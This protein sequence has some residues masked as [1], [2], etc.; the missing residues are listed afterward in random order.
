[1]SDNK[2]TVGREPLLVPI[3]PSRSWSS[4]RDIVRGVRTGAR[5][6]VAAIVARA[7]MQLVPDWRIP[8]GSVRA[9]AVAAVAP[10]LSGVV[11]GALVG[12]LWPWRRHPVTAIALGVA[13]GWIFAGGTA[14]GW[15]G[16]GGWTGYNSLIWLMFGGVFGLTLGALMYD[17]GQP[18]TPESA[19]VTYLQAQRQANS[20][21][22][23]TPWTNCPCC[24]YPTFEQND[25]PPHCMLCEWEEP[26]SGEEGEVTLDQSRA[27]F[28]KFGTIYDPHQLPG[29]MPKPPSAAV[30][31]AREQMRAALDPMALERRPDNLAAL[32]R[33]FY[34]AWGTLR[35]AEARDV[36]AMAARPR[37]RPPDGDS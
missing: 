36:A 4:M 3:T 20:L 7:A 26:A 23:P 19:R 22:K 35:A 5:F 14:A 37:R 25:P 33:S 6:G 21:W 1:M 10:L 18:T 17:L 31:A 27:N 8:F 12:A 24:G 28:A 32:W 16:P 9:V 30:R 11:A 15:S 2:E 34:S 13:A 29:W